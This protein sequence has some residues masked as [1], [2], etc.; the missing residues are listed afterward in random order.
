MKKKKRL[1][2]YPRIATLFILLTLRRK[3]T[4]TDHAN[5]HHKR[6]KRGGCRVKK[7]EAQQ[8]S[9]ILQTPDPK[10]KYGKA[11]P[12]TDRDLLSSLFIYFFEKTALC[13]PRTIPSPL[14]YSLQPTA[15][16][17]SHNT[18]YCSVVYSSTV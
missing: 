10:K 9:F 18:R 3:A 16:D 12:T 6:L 4:S 7:F 15:G 5:C 8:R 17:R 13:T 14:P 11:E 1:Y 2:S